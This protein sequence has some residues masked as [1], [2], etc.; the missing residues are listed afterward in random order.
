VLE[1]CVVCVY[2]WNS[3]CVRILNICHQFTHVNVIAG[4]GVIFIILFLEFI[5]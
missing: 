4:G 5:K 3:N 1:V 2:D